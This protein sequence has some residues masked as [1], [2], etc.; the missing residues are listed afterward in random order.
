MKYINNQLYTSDTNYVT[1]STT[2]TCAWL[3]VYIHTKTVQWNEQIQT[4]K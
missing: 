2:S 1:V 3:C 4:N